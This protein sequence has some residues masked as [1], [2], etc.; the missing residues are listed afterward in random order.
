MRNLIFFI[1]INLLHIPTSVY[2]QNIVNDSVK[3]IKSDTSIVISK[4]LSIK[5]EIYN[6]ISFNIIDYNING[7]QKVLKENLYD[8]SNIILNERD[9]LSIIIQ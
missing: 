7:E 9:T 4:D 3:N 1:I 6:G 5:E 2:A 8:P